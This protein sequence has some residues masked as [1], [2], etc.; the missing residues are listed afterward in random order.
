MHLTSLSFCFCFEFSLLFLKFARFE[1]KQAVLMPSRVPR[2]FLQ[3]ALFILNFFT[4][5]ASHAAV[6]KVTD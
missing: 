5:F 6:T 1:K 4:N 3:V 2:D